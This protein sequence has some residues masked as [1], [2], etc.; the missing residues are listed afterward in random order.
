MK[1]PASLSFRGAY[2]GRFN[3][4]LGDL[5]PSDHRADPPDEA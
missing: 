5:R 2:A 3:L 1:V 4:P